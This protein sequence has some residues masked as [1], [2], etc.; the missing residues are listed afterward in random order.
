MKRVSNWF[1]CEAEE[2]VKLV[3]W[4][5]AKRR[6]NLFVVK[7]NEECKTGLA[8]SRGECQIGLCVEPRRVSNWFGVVTKVTLKFV[9]DGDLGECQIGLG[10][11]PMH[12][13]LSMLTCSN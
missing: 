2:S 4:C 11:R 13:Q 7:A 3:R 8:C 5:R 9:W 1:R 10:W 12:A 6:L